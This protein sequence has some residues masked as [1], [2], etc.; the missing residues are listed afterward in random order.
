MKSDPAAEKKMSLSNNNLHNQRPSKP[1]QITSD[2][3]RLH[4]E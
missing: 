1:T 4:M 3:I 2:Y